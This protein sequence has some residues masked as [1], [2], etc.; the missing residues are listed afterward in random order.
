MMITLTF[1][2]FYQKCN[3]QK[4]RRTEIEQF[5]LGKLIITN[6]RLGVNVVIKTFEFESYQSFFFKYSKQHRELQVL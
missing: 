2:Y 4:G 5:L 1:N 3:W 6:P